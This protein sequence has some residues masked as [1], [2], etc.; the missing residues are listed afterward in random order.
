MVG[1]EYLSLVHVRARIRRERAQLVDELVHP[2]QDRSD[3]RDAAVVRPARAALVLPPKHVSDPAS[4]HRARGGE[5]KKL[6]SHTE[7]RHAGDTDVA[8]TV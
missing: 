6:T 5:K 4:G 8:P 1:L 2:V 3:L 7:S